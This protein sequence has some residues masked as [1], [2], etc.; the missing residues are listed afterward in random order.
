M[1]KV[2]LKQIITSIILSL[3]ILIVPTVTAS[4]LY[5]PDS[6]YNNISF[7]WTYSAP[8]TSSYNC[9]GYATGSMYW[10][11]PWSYNP[12]GLQ[13]DS[14]LS[15]KGHSRIGAYSSGKP[16]GIMA[17]GPSTN[18]ITH[19]SKST[20]P[21]SAMGANSCIAKWGQL[22][23]FKHNSANPYYSSS[24]YGSARIMYK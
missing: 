2:K 6:Y 1:R 10:E 17:Y 22:E 7:T 9:L 12:N 11:W 21:N 20:V 18:V 19:F 8:Y 23:R 3:L 5:Y 13:V 4:A 24:S 14:Y 16:F 15:S